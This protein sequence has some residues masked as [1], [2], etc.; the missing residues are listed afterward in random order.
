MIE[1]W[2][3]RV[4]SGLLLGAIMAAAAI[5]GG[6]VAV[7]AAAGAAICIGVIWSTYAGEEWEAD[8]APVISVLLRR[9]QKCEVHFDTDNACALEVYAACAV[10]VICASAQEAADEI[11]GSRI[12]E[13]AA[14][15]MG[16]QENDTA[17]IKSIRTI[18]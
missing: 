13:T 14:K 10:A 2:I 16:G 18:E 8:Q 4:A 17:E 9:D 11:D 15:I 3:A 7:F 12:L 5:R 1:R 6:L